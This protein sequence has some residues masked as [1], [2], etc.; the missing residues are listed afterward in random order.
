MGNNSW[1]H[2]IEIHKKEREGMNTYAD[3]VFFFHAKT[4]KASVKQL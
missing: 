1:C 4:P 3:A 2:L